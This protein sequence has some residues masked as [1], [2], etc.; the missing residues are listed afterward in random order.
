M[1]RYYYYS[2]DSHF[3][4]HDSDGSTDDLSEALNQYAIA[5]D[6]PTIVYAC[7]RDMVTKKTMREY[8]T[9]TIN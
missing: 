2:T 6:D 5:A 8:W 7:V 4:G 3:G 9:K 1:K